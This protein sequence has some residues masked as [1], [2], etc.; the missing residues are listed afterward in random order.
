[1]KY[2]IKHHEKSRLDEISKEDWE[3]ARN[4]YLKLNKY[5]INADIF[6]IESGCYVE[7]TNVVRANYKFQAYLKQQA[8]EARE[9]YN[10]MFGKEEGYR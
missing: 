1:M 10:A 2:F 6:C 4:D 5:D 8:W 7:A 9:F 3:K